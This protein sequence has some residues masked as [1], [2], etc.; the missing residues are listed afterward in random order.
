MT[1]EQQAALESVV[2][3]ALEPSEIDAIDPLL[4]DRRDTEIA[5]VL[6]VGRTRPNGVQVGNGTILETI[7]LQAGNELLD[8]LYGEAQF[9]HV[10]PLLEQGRLIVS[11]PIVTATLTEMVGT[12]LTQEQANALIALGQ[13]PDPISVNAV[14][15]ALN[16]AEGRA[17]L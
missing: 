5:A 1:P 15:D 9:R 13:D 2:G 11:S 10:K 6:S 8:Y 16:F 4:P 7:G 14:S 12:L 17:V 3:R